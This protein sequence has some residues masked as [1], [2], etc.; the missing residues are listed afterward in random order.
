MSIFSL[1]DVTL[2]PVPMCSLPPQEL[3]WIEKFLV[4]WIIICMG[5]GLLISQ[6]LEGVSDAINDFKVGEISIPIGVCLF[7]M[8]YP[9]LMNL[10]VSELKKVVKY[11]KVRVVSVLL[12]S[13]VCFHLLLFTPFVR[14]AVH[15]FRR[16][17]TAASGLC[18][19]LFAQPVGTLLSAKRI[20]F[21]LYVCLLFRFLS[22]SLLSQ[23]L[24]ITFISNWIF[25]PLV[26]TGLAYLIMPNDKQLQVAVILLGAS[27]W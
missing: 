14:L 2:V 22:L 12:L 16:F 10:R 5:V 9:A 11:P 3:D 6:F 4:L 8:M 13:T 1:L 20:R 18:G 21:S 26:S 27:P 17:S 25:A 19:V 15:L 23:A 24:I 7:V